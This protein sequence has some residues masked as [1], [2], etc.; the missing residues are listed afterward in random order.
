LILP[1][2]GATVRG[3]LAYSCIEFSRLLVG[4]TRTETVIWKRI[5]CLVICEVAVVGSSACGE[6][7][8]LAAVAV[9]HSNMRQLAPILECHRESFGG[10]PQTLAQVAKFMGTCSAAHWVSEARAASEGLQYASYA[11]RYTPS[12]QTAG[13]RFT[14]YE[15][16]A[17]GRYDASECPRCRSFWLDESGVLRSAP[18]RLAGR[19]DEPMK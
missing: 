8:R 18:G 10:Y 16:L 2:H 19:N 17:S 4:Q 3:S 15:L 9:A 5:V 11:Y 12:G 13:G 1:R 14:R 7:R 6:D